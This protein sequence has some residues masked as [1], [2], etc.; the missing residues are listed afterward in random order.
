[1][2]QAHVSARLSGQVWARLR[3]RR[4]GFRVQVFQEFVSIPNLYEHNHSITPPSV[5]LP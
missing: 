3:F 2:S 5:H 4:P 1:M